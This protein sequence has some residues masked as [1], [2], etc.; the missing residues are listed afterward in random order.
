MSFKFETLDIWKLALELADGVYELTRKFPQDERFELTSQTR[1]SASS[2]P[3][4]I[5]EG[6]GGSSVKDFQNYLDIAIKS[7]YETVSHLAL[8]RRRGYINESK[9][10]EQKNKAEALIRKIKAFKGWLTKRE[11]F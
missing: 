4:N 1:R 11:R 6:S 7:I 8:A 3:A 10:T 9:Y 2:V 5:A